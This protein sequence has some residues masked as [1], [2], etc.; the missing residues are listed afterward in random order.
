MQ[1]R[2]VFI[3]K[4]SLLSIAL[5]I[6]GLSKAAWASDSIDISNILDLSDPASHC[7]QDHDHNGLPW[8]LE[9][10][11]WK[12]QVLWSAQDTGFNEGAMPAV[13]VLIKSG[14]P[15]PDILAKALQAGGEQVLGNLWP[16][17][18]M[19]Q[20]AKSLYQIPGGLG[21]KAAIAIVVA[22]QWHNCH[23]FRCLVAHTDEI[24]DWLRLS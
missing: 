17:R 19:M 2:R 4:S 9:D 8:S 24:G 6:N 12:D 14:L 21:E 11:P 16:R 1:S 7:N 3:V 18:D 15:V 22:S 5:Q 20:F 23:A 13:N 10:C